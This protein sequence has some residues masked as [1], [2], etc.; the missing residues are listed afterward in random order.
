[1]Y[2]LISSYL[3]RSGILDW[4]IFLIPLLVPRGT[5]LTALRGRDG[6]REGGRERRKIGGKKKEKTIK[7]K[8]IKPTSA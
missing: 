3:L 5:T 2:S 8:V 4:A 6:G 7:G 1:M